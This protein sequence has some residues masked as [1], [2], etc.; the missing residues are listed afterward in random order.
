MASP[1]LEIQ[2]EVVRLLKAD[3]DVMT[4]VNGVYDDVPTTCWPPPKEGFIDIGDA[5]TLRQDASCLEGGDIYLT[6]HAWSRKVGF[7]AVRAIADAMIEALHMAALTMPTHRFISMMHR[8]TR[9]FRDPDGKTSHAV[10]EF[11]VR[12]DRAA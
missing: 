12:Y 1:E 5:H 10:V 4:L 11:V 6:M 7:P 3:A 9:V 2:G 8:Q